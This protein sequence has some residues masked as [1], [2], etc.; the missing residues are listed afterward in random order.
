MSRQLFQRR[1][2]VDPERLAEGLAAFVDQLAW[3]DAHPGLSM[4]GW[5]RTDPGGETG[6][7]LATTIYT[8]YDWFLRE[9]AR[10][11]TLGDY[12]PVND[13]AATLTVGTDVFERWDA[14]AGLPT[15]WALPTTFFWQVTG[16]S[17]QAGDE[18]VWTTVEG[19]DGLCAWF[20]DEAQVRID[21]SLRREAWSR[22]H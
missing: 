17:A 1:R 10:L 3:I 11:Q 20:R 22:I 4:A 8:D 16:P 14:P 19:V 2:W 21:E 7:I 13:L 18:P 5:Q 15:D 6:A 9:V 12:A